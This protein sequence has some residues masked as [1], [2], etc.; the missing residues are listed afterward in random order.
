MSIPSGF[1]SGLILFS[2]DVCYV[3]FTWNTV[4]FYVYIF[5]GFLSDQQV[6]YF[7]VNFSYT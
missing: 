7:M 5:T 3:E 6:I 4:I 2:Q 1:D